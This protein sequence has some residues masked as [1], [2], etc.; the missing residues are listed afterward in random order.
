MAPK[1]APAVSRIRNRIIA[2]AAMRPVAAVSAAEAMPVMSI[3]TISGI[4]VMRR[5]FSHSAPM[6]SS[7][8][9]V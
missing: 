3:E 1:V 2:R 6:G 7:A 9:T 5:P 8:G 4:M